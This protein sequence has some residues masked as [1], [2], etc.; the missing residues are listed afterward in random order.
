MIIVKIVLIIFIGLS[1][2]LIWF[3]FSKTESIN[4][5][6]SMNEKNYSFDKDGLIILPQPSK[7]S[8]VSIE[9]ALLNR[10]SVREYKDEALKP[11]EISQILWAVQGITAPD[12]G[13]RSAPSA[14]ALY[15]LETYLV[16]RKA[17]SLESG[18]YHYIPEGHKIKR[19][20]EKDISND[21]AEAGLGQM[22]IKQAAIN[23]IITAVFSRTTSKYGERGNQYVYMEAGHASQNIYLQVESLGLGT[24]TV[25]AFNDEGVKNVLNLP[26]NETPLYIMPVGKVKK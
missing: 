6:Q 16:V 5:N 24:V 23:I 10:R 26:E 12:W 25:G 9:Q 2:I 21:L 3:L 11:G 22:F 4:Q 1:I 17:E 7:E 18:V 13:G 14:G 20:L 19:I 15:P 8:N